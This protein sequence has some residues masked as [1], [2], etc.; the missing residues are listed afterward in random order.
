MAKKLPPR[1]LMRIAWRIHR[2]VLSTTGGRAGLS[3]PTPG[4]KVGMLQLHTVG[5]KSGKPRA[6]VLNYIDDGDNMV[7][8]ASNGGAPP[9][10][11]WWLNLKARPEAV[12]DIAGGRRTVYAREAVGAE[13]DRLV[14]ILRGY[15][16]YE[17]LDEILA[18]R[19]R[20]TP[21][22]VLAPSPLP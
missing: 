11:A 15:A 7:T 21:V 5:R 4:S 20:E 1:W 6:V 2:V 18:R 22:V 10:P 8:L 17:D 13:H 14:A 9:D 19:G 16:G 12:V 3:T